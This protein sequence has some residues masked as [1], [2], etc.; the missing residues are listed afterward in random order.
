MQQHQVYRCISSVTK[1]NQ[2]GRPWIS[3]SGALN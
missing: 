3:Y 2:C 1:G